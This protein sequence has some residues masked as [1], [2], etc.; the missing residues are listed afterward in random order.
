MCSPHVLM[1]V[2][3]LPSMPFYDLL[4]RLAEK[5]SCVS[6]VVS[7]KSVWNTIAKDSAMPTFLLLFL[8]LV[9]VAYVGYTTYRSN[10]GRR[11]IEKKR[12][13]YHDRV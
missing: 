6:G 7:K 11:A 1:W 4:P 5:R 10:A 9:I 8:A 2:R 13:Q 3:I 12:N